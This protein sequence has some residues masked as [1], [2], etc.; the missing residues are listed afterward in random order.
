[1]ESSL[2]STKDNESCTSNF[3]AGLLSTELFSLQIILCCTGTSSSGTAKP[4]NQRQ[5]ADRRKDPA[6]VVHTTY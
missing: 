2:E 5:E 1:M 6:V 3:K 4:N